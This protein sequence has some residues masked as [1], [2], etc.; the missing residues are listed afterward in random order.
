M[1]VCGPAILF[2]VLYWCSLGY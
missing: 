1:K 2:E